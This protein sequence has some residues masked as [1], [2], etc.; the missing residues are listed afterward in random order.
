MMQLRRGAIELERYW[1]LALNPEQGIARAR[2]LFER[3]EQPPPG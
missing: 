1:Y 3:L 2:A